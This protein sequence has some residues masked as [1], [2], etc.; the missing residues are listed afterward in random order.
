MRQQL[1]W[2]LS[3]A[4]LAAC[5]PTDST[6]ADVSDDGVANPNTPPL[7]PM[8]WKPTSGETLY[9]MVSGLARFSNIKN[10]SERSNI[11]KVIWP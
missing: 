2:V 7:G 4:I 3:L 9:F 5:Q 6:R 8:N 1:P 11:V 10:V